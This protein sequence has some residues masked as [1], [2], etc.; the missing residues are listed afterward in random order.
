M[1]KRMCVPTYPTEAG[2]SPNYTCITKTAVGLVPDNYRSV[3]K[4]APFVR[5]LKCRIAAFS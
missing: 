5:N 1:S 4:N 3:F 2:H